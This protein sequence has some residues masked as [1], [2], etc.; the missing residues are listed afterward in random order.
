MGV[1]GVCVCVRSSNITSGKGS[2]HISLE[3]G[4]NVA[5]SF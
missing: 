2:L 1:Y 3:Q 4:M 5:G